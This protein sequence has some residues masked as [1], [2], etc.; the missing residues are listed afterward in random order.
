MEHSFR[1]TM[2]STLVGLALTDTRAANPQKDRPP[3]GHDLAGMPCLTLKQ[4]D[5]KNV[6]ERN[7]IKVIRVCA[8]HMDAVTSAQA[9][10]VPASGSSQAADAVAGAALAGRGRGGRGGRGG[11][12]GG[13]RTSEPSPFAVDG[14]SVPRLGETG[15][16]TWQGDS[17]SGLGR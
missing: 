1:F 10:A 17:A 8:Y 14:H 16:E 7:V 13:G 3:F 15:S 9:V 2:R 12:G 4:I 5:S 6:S 11:P